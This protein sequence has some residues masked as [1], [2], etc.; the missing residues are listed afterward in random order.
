MNAERV[1]AGLSA[2]TLPGVRLESVSFTPLGADDGKFEGRRVQGIRL[3]VTDR[4]LYDP[5]RTAV[6]LLLA[7][8]KS[9]DTAW[10]WQPEAFDRLAG[11]DQLRIAVDSGAPADEIVN[12]WADARHHFEKS[13]ARYLLYP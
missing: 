3:E 7:V 11:T 2:E 6:A 9:A 4:R 8:R 5:T 10:A 12:D 13:R 1:L